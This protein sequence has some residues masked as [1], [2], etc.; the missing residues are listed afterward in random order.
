MNSSTARRR[1]GAKRRRSTWVLPPPARHLPLSASRE[2]AN[3]RL[4]FSAPGVLKSLRQTSVACFKFYGSYTLVTG[5][6][7]KNGT[8][9]R[10]V[11]DVVGILKL[12]FLRQLRC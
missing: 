11:R 4:L 12:R 5:V 1:A 2:V 10:Q 6:A 3:K 9:T 7:S 8:D